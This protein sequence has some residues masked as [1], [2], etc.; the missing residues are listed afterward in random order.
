M[1]SPLSRPADVR[2]RELLA[3]ARAARR[4]LIMGILNVTP[5][6]FS[7][8]GLY[9]APEQ[10]LSHA[11]QM[12]EE[13]ADILDIGGESTRPATFAT[14]MPLPIEEEMR[15]VLPV[16]AAVSACLPDVPLSIDTYKAEV[17]RK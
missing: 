3:L 7:D 13:G 16:V 10:A 6:S 15:R 2:L 14:Q 9:F 8:G 4:T 1:N 11:R 5:D 12:V 17:A